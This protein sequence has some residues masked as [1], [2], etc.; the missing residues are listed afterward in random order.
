MHGSNALVSIIAA[1]SSGRY[2]VQSDDF[3]SLAVPLAKLMDSL[4]DQFR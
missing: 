1:K 4:Q 2:R 3:A